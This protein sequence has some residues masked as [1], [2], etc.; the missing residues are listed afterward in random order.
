[1][2]A[3]NEVSRL[4]L[5]CRSACCPFNTL[6]AH[7]Y[8]RFRRHRVHPS[9]RQQ[10]LA[11]C[12]P[13]LELLADAAQAEA[14]YYAAAAAGSSSSD[15]NGSAAGAVDHN[16]G[17]G[18]SG[19]EGHSAERQPSS[20]S[21]STSTTAAVKDLQDAAAEAL[22]KCLEAA[23]AVTPGSDL[24]CILAAKLEAVATAAAAAGGGASSGSQGGDSSSSNSKSMLAAAHAA[25]VSAHTARYGP[26]TEQQRQRLAEFNRT[27]YV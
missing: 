2:S 24:H 19:G 26:L 10:L 11:S 25:C 17:S 27:L 6:I 5:T 20:S 18:V 3:S 4:F 13:A 16:N 22:R 15:G 23:A 14:D 8:N 21:T 7:R 1:M 9:L 12:F